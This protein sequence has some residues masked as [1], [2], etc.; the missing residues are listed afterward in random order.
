MKQNNDVADFG[1]LELLKF[2]WSTLQKSWKTLLPMFIVVFLVNLV[3]QS[4]VNSSDGALSFFA[5]LASWCLISLLSAGLIYSGLKVLRGKD[6]QLSDLISQ[7]E[8]FLQYLITSF[9]YSLLIIFGFF[10][11]IIPGVYWLLKYAFVL[12]LVVDKKQSMK[13]AF[14]ESSQMTKGQFG[15][16]LKFFVAA[17]FINMIGALLFGLGLIITAPVTFIAYLEMYRRMKG[18][19]LIDKSSKVVEGEIVS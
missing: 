4:I 2:G 1:S 18:E 11:L 10:L 8:V 7:T 14:S 9:V 15:T 17:V 6:A 13:E 5:N 3:T 19:S 16:L 12:E